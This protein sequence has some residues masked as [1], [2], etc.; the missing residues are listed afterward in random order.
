MDE[1]F[2]L[3]SKGENVESHE[4]IPEDVDHS[5]HKKGFDTQSQK[6]ERKSIVSCYFFNLLLKHTSQNKT[7]YRTRVNVNKINKLVSEVLACH[8]HVTATPWL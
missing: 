2:E 5:K 4:S 3:E 7:K 1:K 6:P 8:F